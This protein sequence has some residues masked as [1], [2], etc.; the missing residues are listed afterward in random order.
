M[1]KEEKDMTLEEFSIHMEG[2]IEEQGQI[3]RAD[4]YT[5]NKQ[6]ALYEDSYTIA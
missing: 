4:I 6:K 2:F 3:L 5:Y 1:K